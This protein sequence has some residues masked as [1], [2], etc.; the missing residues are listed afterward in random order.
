M[1]LRK[2]VPMLAAATTL[3]ASATP[4]YAFDN[5]S[6]AGGSLPASPVAVSH[7]AGSSDLAVELAAGGI[8][9]AGG[10]LA[11]MQLRRRFARGA[12]SARVASGS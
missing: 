3:F 10:G 7:S 12:H 8:V 1:R 11:A 5:E 6:P 4:A 2:S 9:I